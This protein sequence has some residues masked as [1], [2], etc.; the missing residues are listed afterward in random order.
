MK[1]TI[2]RYNETNDIDQDTIIL[3]FGDKKTF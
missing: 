3:S 1:D 2:E